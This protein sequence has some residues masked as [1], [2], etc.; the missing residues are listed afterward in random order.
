M[1]VLV[2][3]ATG[4]VGSRLVRAL[5]DAG[6]EVSALVRDASNAELPA[7]VHV[8]EGDLLET[9]GFRLVDD[10][11][12]GNGGNTDLR[13]S[14]DRTFEDCLSAHGVEAAYYLVHSM[15]SGSDFEERDRRA[16][17][18]FERGVSAAGVE[19]VVYLG[20]LG[21]E[22]DHL[23]PHLRSRREV[24]YVL[25]E[26]DYDLTTLRA[27]IIIGDGSASFEVIRQLADRLP[28]M[29]T[30]RWVDTE[31]QP[32]YVDDVV[33]YLVGVLDAPETAGETYEIGGPDVL[34]YGEVLKRVGE[35]LDRQTRLVSVPVLTPRLSSYW[36]SLVTNV[37]TSVSRPLIEG[38]KNPVVVR[39]DSIKRHV[40]VELTP[41][42]EAVT[43][44]LG[45]VSESDTEPAVE[46][47]ETVG[48]DGSDLESSAGSTET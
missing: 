41:F 47:V 34:T 44:A 28:V 25:G 13:E 35:H 19:R 17:R 5:L 6:H 32:I 7:D 4:F 11:D 22:R 48:E 12:A 10:G 29:V 39:D 27:A 43:R 1:K 42:D 33:S 3:G 30:P 36:V 23:S 26:G 45:A 38:L 24:E 9:G 8:I 46:P 14:D 2:T 16:A 31:C 37:P 20:G 21:E 18:H 40:E 15:Q